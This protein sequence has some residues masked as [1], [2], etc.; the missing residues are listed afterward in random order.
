MK[1]KTTGLIAAPPTAFRADGC[2]DLNAVRPMAD[3]LHGQGVS[4]VFVN[5]TTGE[6]ASLTIE[7]RQQLVAVWRRVLP[8]G[9]KLFVHV[10]HNAI[11]EACG[12]ARHAVAEGADAIAAIAPGYFRPDGISGV[13]DW[14]AQI[15]AAAPSLPFYYYHMPSISGLSLSVTEF[16]DHASARIPN[17]A[18]VKFTHENMADYL[19]ARTG[20]G[21]RFDVLWGRDEML[22]GALAMGAEGAVGST[23]NVM[24][25]LY[26]EMIE[27][28]HRADWARARNLQAQCIGV[29][30]AMVATGNFFAALKWILRAQGVPILPTVRLPLNPVSES[31]LAGLHP[32]IP[33]MRPPGERVA[34]QDKAIC[35][36]LS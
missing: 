28:F 32:P 17:L 20:H 22:L 24:A 7:E 6:G 2:V 35:E 4:A 9:M 16:L 23:Y 10:G 30:N 27:A 19:T 25:P 12:L 14:C 33:G 15:A 11:G 18:G 29:I 5:G 13:T 31:K 34:Q 3:H 21:G 1:S 26:V 36:V 8:T